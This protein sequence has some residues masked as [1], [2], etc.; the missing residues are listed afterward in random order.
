MLNII[1]IEDEPATARNLHFS[2]QEIEDIGLL[3]TLVSVKEAVEWLRENPQTYDLVFMDIRLTDGLS[4]EIFQQV[5]V[6]SPVI[7]VTA[8]DEY[9]LQ[10]FKTNGIDYILK[11]FELAELQQSMNKFRQLSQPANQ[12]MGMEQN[13]AT[14]V[15]KFAVGIGTLRVRVRKKSGYSTAL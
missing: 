15:T 5:K 2:L 11:P 1:I 9:A 6:N 3:A 12:I 7:F 4:F 8:Y 14:V 13:A 10:A